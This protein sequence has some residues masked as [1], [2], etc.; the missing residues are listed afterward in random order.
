MRL[1]RKPLVAGGVALGLVGGALLFARTADATTYLSVTLSAS[2]TGASAVWNSAGDPVLTVGTPS[3]STYAEITIDGVSGT[4]A[5]SSAP[6]FDTSNYT[7]GSPRWVLQFADGDALFGYPAQAGLTDANWAVI[8]A[9]SGACASQKPT[10]QYDTYAHQLAFIDNA[11][12]GGNV[13]GAFIIADGNQP[14]G[15]SDTITNVSYNGETLAPGADVVTVAQPGAQTS[16]AGTAISTLQLSAS[17]SKNDTITAWAATGLPPGLSIDTS[18]GA[19]SGTPNTAGNYQVT[20]TAT[21]S[22]GTKG[23]V[24]FTWSVNSASTPP[25]G[26]TTYSGA[27]RLVKFGLCLDDRFNSSTPGAVVQ[28]WGCNGLPNQQ[29]QVESNGT[30]E[31]NGLCLDARGFGTTSGTKVQLWTC[32]GA[33]NQKWDTS[34][35]HIHYDNPAASGQVLDDTGWGGSGTQ[36]DIWVNNGGANQIWATV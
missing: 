12:C 18:T 24:S 20:V 35:W 33:N 11:G 34:S 19:I 3:D 31:H 23:S 17:S 27:I 1:K 7:G 6:S 26:S 15:T 22:G 25:S 13:T 8:P 4:A 14:A 30:I 16:T 29:W 5:P 2:G 10:P 32:T 21:D 9:S 36:Q 28:V